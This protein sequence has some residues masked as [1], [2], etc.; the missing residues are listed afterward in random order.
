MLKVELCGE[1]TCSSPTEV[2]SGSQSVNIANLSAGA[3]AAIIFK[4][5]F[6]PNLFLQFLMDMELVVM[7]HALVMEVLRLMQQLCM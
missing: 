4:A 3:E 5:F 7:V 6:K 2:A 1:V